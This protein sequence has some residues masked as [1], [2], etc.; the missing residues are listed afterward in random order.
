M[1]RFQLF[2][3]TKFLLTAL[4][5]L[6]SGSVFSADKTIVAFAF[7][8]GDPPTSY[9][10]KGGNAVGL[11]PD[12]VALAFE[13]I[14]Q[15]EATLSAYPWLRAK[16]RVENGQSDG[17]FTYPGKSVSEYA[18]FTDNPA[19]VI[20]Y[21]Y[22]FYASDNE[23]LEALEAAVTSEELTAFTL[24]TDSN[25]DNV[26][27]EESN[28]PNNKFKR[29]YV[30]DVEVAMHMLVRRHDGDFLVRNPEEAMFLAKKLGYSNKIKFHRILF[31][32][33]NN[34]PFHF[35]IRLSHPEHDEIMAEL[36][37]VVATD[38]FQQKAK[39]IIAGYQ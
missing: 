3:R 27:W 6:I 7:S 15:Y 1:T 9:A 23:R 22:I 24:I 17:L 37:R 32:S 38:Q 12:L 34:L 20:D 29:V 14:P 13:Q 2:H 18:S 8:D 11:L 5:I 35:G 30:E 19:Y 39:E 4:I 21:N 33:E 16:F 31:P 10:D 25:P 28:L 36:N 26:S